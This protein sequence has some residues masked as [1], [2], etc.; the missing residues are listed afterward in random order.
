MMT[1]P[2]CQPGDTSPEEVSKTIEARIASLDPLRAEALAGLQILRTARASLYTREQERLKRKYS[3]D[4]P[5]VL[6]LAKKANFNEGLRRDISFEIDRAKIEAPTVDK[7]GYIFHGFVRDRE[8]RGVSRLTVCLYDNEGK[9]NREFGYGCTD[10]RGYFLLRYE[11]RKKKK[12]GPVEPGLVARVE[13]D[14]DIL[15]ARI[16]V[17]NSEHVTLHIE[18]EPL[19]PQASKVDFRIMILGIEPA[20]CEPPPTS[21][22]ASPA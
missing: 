14:V 4:S 5:R 9:V 7:E 15:S 2:S 12:K 21:R 11:F 18:K 17:L 3:V 13:A 19:Y 22:Q 8:G 20:P 16:Y 10:E 1:R 6:T